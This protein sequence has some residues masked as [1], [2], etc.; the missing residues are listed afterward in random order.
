MIAETARISYKLNLGR[1]ASVPRPYIHHE[2]CTHVKEKAWTSAIV[3]RNS[4]RG[5]QYR[6]L[7]LAVGVA[8]IKLQAGT[9]P[10]SGVLRCRVVATIARAS[11]PVEV[12]ANANEHDGRGH[13]HDNASF[14]VRRTSRC[15][16]HRFIVVVINRSWFWPTRG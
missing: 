1:W 11:L 15:R 6:F 5:Q 12:H 4:R 3:P 14:A 8:D 7:R 16:G 9:V 2:E 13:T 10:S